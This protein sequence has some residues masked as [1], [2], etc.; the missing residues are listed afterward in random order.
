[1]EANLESEVAV[2]ETLPVRV[3]AD[4]KGVQPEDVRV[5][6]VYGPLS[7]EGRV[8]GGNSI[9]LEHCGQ[10][11]E[12][13]HCFEGR[14]PCTIS[15]EHGFSVRILPVHKGLTHPFETGLVAWWG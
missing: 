3:K 12:G 4:L 5:E 6:L 11:S 13:V 7:A 15:G 9:P 8:E 10:A 14:L 1:M 2:G